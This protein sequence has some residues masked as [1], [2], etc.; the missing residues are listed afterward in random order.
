M[1]SCRVSSRRGFTLIEL[2]VVIAIIAILIGLLLPAVQKVREAANRMKCGNNLKQLALGVHG[3]HDA[4]G[5]MPYNGSTVAGFGDCCGLGAPRWSWIARILPYIEQDN[6]FR[7]AN[8]SDTTNM[9]A[10]ATVLAAIAQKINTLICPSDNALNPM[11]DRANVAPTPIGITNYKGVAGGNWGNGEARWRWGT[12][13]G[14]F[15]SWL[16]TNDHSGVLNGNG[17]FWRRDF[18][19]KKSLSQ[20]GDGTSNTFMIGEDVP[21]LNTHCSWPYSNGAVGTCGI[22]PNSRQTNG[23]PYNPGDWPN[24]YSFRSKHSGG[25]QFALADGSVRYIKETIN[26][27][28]YR[29]MASIVGGE[30][31][32][33]DN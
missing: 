10:N 15:N 22:G 14:P 32:S 5:E 23:Q 7:Q 2:L 18:A 16:G 9:N 11:T 33:P 6:L 29:A 24:V 26:I 8:V 3:Y 30:I 28:T 21:A 25:L 12:P 4:N 20:I 31:A 17:I 19:A 13:N 27:A 1:V